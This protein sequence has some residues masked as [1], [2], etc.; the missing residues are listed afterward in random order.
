M[1]DFMLDS[2][3]QIWME[4]LDRTKC[5]WRLA[6]CNF[7]AVIINHNHKYVIQLEHSI[8]FI[9][10]AESGLM[11]ILLPSLIQARQGE[12]LP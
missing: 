2:V 10:L 1:P 11:L 12:R 5:Y 3:L 6:M 9:A 7:P 4:M 8:L